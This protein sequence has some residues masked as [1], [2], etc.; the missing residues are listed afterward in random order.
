MKLLTINAYLPDRP[1]AFVSRLS[2]PQSSS[3]MRAALLINV[4]LTGPSK[5]PPYHRLT[6]T[7]TSRTCMFA[8]AAC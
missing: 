8:N 6:T 2:Y 4:N 7:T 1:A 5:V 3:R